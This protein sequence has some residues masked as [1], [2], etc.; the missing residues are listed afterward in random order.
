MTTQKNADGIICKALVVAAGLGVAGFL[1]YLWV[2]G[3]SATGLLVA[4]GMTLFVS[5]MT[6]AGAALMFGSKAQ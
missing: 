1:F 3:V 5:A 6:V 2:L 4:L